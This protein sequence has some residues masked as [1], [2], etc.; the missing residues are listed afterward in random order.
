VGVEVTHAIRQV[1]AF[2]PRG[3]K[4]D[5]IDCDRYLVALVENI[6]LVFELRL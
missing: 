2:L 6:E 5:D 3:D 1:G 4:P